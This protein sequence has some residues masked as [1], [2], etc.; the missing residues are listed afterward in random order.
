MQDEHKAMAETLINNINWLVED[1]MYQM[2]ALRN[3]LHV[4]DKDWR[5]VI[6]ADMLMIAFSIRKAKLIRRKLT[7]YSAKWGICD[8]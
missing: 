8:A 4:A 3:R 5:P 1:L 7:T 2:R 6:R